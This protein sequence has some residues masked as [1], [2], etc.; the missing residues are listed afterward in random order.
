MLGKLFCAVLVSLGMAFPSLSYSQQRDRGPEGVDHNRSGSPEHRSA[1]DRGS[2]EF[3]PERFVRERSSQGPV[4]SPRSVSGSRGRSESPLSNPAWNDRRTTGGGDRRSVVGRTLP[5]REIVGWT[6][7]R[8]APRTARVEPFQTSRRSDNPSFGIGRRDGVRSEGTQMYRGVIQRPFVNRGRTTNRLFL[9]RFWGHR[10]YDRL[11][12]RYRDF[13]P[14]F[15]GIYL[16]GHPHWTPFRDQWGWIPV[17]WRD[18]YGN[19]IRLYVYYPSP[20]WWLTDRVLVDTMDPYD[21][22]SYAEGYSDGYQNEQI[23]EAEK[24]QLRSQIRDELDRNDSE[25]KAPLTIFDAF[26][27]PEYR[28]LVSRNVTAQL[29]QSDQEC[30]LFKGAF[31]QTVQAPGEGE[32]VALMKVVT[33]KGGTCPVGSEVFVSLDDLQNFLNDLTQHIENGLGTYEQRR[34]SPQVSENP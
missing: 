21:S 14:N 23:S 10:T 11:L 12:P 4:S 20:L 32:N 29:S 16:G 22:S 9:S 8:P 31:L 27:D 3:R 34:G 33:T 24:A 19:Y 15:W 6:V 2:H 17:W 1:P 25:E 13:A 5:S 7:V 26:K 30:R 18:E 28:F